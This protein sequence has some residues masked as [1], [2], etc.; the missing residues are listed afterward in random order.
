MYPNTCFVLQQY[1]L[2]MVFISLYHFYDIQV[3]IGQVNS[4]VNHITGFINRTQS[5]TSSGVEL[6]SI[7]LLC[8]VKT[9]IIPSILVENL[10]NHLG[11]GRNNIF[12]NRVSLKNGSSIEVLAF[13]PNCK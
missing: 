3:A 5:F 6:L 7:G 13:Q 4:T 10:R 9:S 1:V 11:N 2:Y 12:P 8:S